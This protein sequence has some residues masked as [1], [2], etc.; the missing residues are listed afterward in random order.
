M[1]SVNAGRHGNCFSDNLAQFFGLDEGLFRN[2]CICPDH[3]AWIIRAS[4]EPITQRRLYCRPKLAFLPKSSKLPN[5]IGII[6]N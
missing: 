3:F 2:E 6:R 1:P 4:D 5:P